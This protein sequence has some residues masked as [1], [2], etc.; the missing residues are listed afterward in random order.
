MSNTKIT[1]GQENIVTDWQVAVE[2]L[3]GNFDGSPR[4]VTVCKVTPAPGDEVEAMRIERLFDSARDIRFIQFT[5]V[6]LR[7]NENG[8]V[9]AY[10]DVVNRHKVDIPDDDFAYVEQIVNKTIRE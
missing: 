6:T 7:A 4:R 3:Q 2:C 1:Q 8:R 9:T 5:P 10:P